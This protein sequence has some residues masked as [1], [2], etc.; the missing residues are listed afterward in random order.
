MVKGP[1][2]LNYAALKALT[3]RPAPTF[4]RAVLEEIRIGSPGGN[5]TM[6]SFAGAYSDD[7]IA[8]V[9]NYVIG[10]PAA[11]KAKSG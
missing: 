11:I 1:I 10:H 3:I 5:D 6:P 7:E 8:S 9:S 2:M 4:V